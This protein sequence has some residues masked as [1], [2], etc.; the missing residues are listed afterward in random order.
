MIAPLLPDELA[1]LSKLQYPIDMR[2]ANELVMS[3]PD[4]WSV[5]Q[6]EVEVSW[7]PNYVELRCTITSPEGRDPARAKPTAALDVAVEEMVRLHKTFGQ[8]LTKVTS[9]ATKEGESCGTCQ[10]E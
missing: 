9:V 8:R 4:T 5:I 6:L 10:Q 2:I 1:K 3:T 7:H